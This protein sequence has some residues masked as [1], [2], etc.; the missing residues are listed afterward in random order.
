[1][2][3]AVGVVIGGA[4]AVGYVAS[5]A[6]DVDLDRLRPAN[7]GGNSVVFAADGTKLGYIDGP[8]LRTPVRSRDMSPLVRQATVAVEDRRFYQ[9]GGVDVEGIF[10]AA[11]RNFTERETKEGA[12]T[13]EMQ[14]IRN[15]YT[16]DKDDSYKRKIR[17]AKLAD[18]LEKRHPGREGKEWVLTTYLNSVPYGNAPNGQNIIGVQAAARVYFNK[19]AKDLTLAQA[20]LI[21]G[22]PQAPSQYNPFRNPKAALV[23]RNDVL[24]RMAEQGY[25][26]GTTAAEA[27]DAPLGLRNGDFYTRRREQFVMDYVRQELIEKY[28]RKRVREG[29]LKIYTTIDLKKQQQARAA[30]QKNF[31]PGGPA[32][33]IVSI[34]PESGDV[35]TMAS[36]AQYSDT[37]YN[38]VTQGKRQPGSTFKTMVLMAALRAGIDPDSTVYTSRSGEELLPGWSPKTYS[39]K[40]GGSMSITKATLASDNSVYAQLDLDVGPENVTKAAR[41]MGITSKLISAP[42]EGLGGLTDGVSPLEVARAYS[43]IANGGKRIVPRIVTKVV[44]QDGTVRRPQKVK[45]VRTFSAGVASKANE[46]LEK[47]VQGGTGKSAA[48]PNCPVAGKTGTTDNEADAWFAGFTRDMTTVAWVGYPLSRNPTGEQGGGRPARTWH[49][50]M[51]AAKGSSCGPFRKAPFSGTRGTGAHAGSRG[52]EKTGPDGQ[53]LDGATGADGAATPDGGGTAVD[54]ATPGR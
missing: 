42:A 30:L 49:D 10:R 1:M 51:I 40:S 36:T 27:Q 46:I 14:L 11:L 9:H 31:I 41:L 2:T 7:P 6:D 15:L 37:K 35:T 47:N 38:L 43:T 20:A 18:Q 48:L 4:G 52:D 3:I 13:L 5:I 39:G 19:S 21:A 8:V 16:G 32:S 53:P 44:L 45:A 29:G 23:R 34:R 50:F 17:E 22:L 26:T 12:S 25:V 33:A 28:G 54:P 24:R